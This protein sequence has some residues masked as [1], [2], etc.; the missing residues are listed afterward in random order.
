MSKKSR[1]R[2]DTRQSEKQ[3]PH[4]L[5]LQQEAAM[6]AAWNTSIFAL[7]IILSVIAVLIIGGT[8]EG[9]GRKALWGL[10]VQIPIGAVYTVQAIRRHRLNRMVRRIQ[11]NDAYDIRIRCTKVRFMTKRITKYT[12]VIYAMEVLDETETAFFYVFPIGDERSD[13]QT[14]DL[15]KC[16]VAHELTLTCYTDTHIVKSFPNNTIPKGD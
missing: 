6:Q 3:I 10:L 16:L 15:R 2:S 4:C 12:S 8:S 9:D 7:I 11:S 13:Y 5:H 14:N 1:A